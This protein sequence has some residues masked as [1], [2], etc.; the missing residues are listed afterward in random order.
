MPITMKT[1][2]TILSVAL[3]V[4]LLTACSDPS[5]GV[6][7]SEA[8]DPKQAAAAA[9]A[10][11]KEY[12]IRAESRIGFVGSKVTGSHTGGFSN[13]TGT[14]K[15]ANGKIVG[16][17]AIKI[18]MGSTWA[19]NPRVANHLKNQ[20]FFDVPKFPTSTFTVTSIEPTNTQQLV[21]GNLELHGVTKSISFPADIQISEDD[22]TVKADF[23]IN[24]RDF[25]INYRGMAND[26]VRDN[27]VIK[28][29]I[30][31]TPGAASPEDQLVN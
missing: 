1:H 20:D 23:A 21:T 5:K 14:I 2:A 6:H 12:V 15:V 27:V 10:V 9:A 8:S 4:C 31:A 25:G 28:L 16:S 17:P 18:G 30:K 24:R 22:V 29:D 26:L 7:K 13:F 11:E 19:D 3:I